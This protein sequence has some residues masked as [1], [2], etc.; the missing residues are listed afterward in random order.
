MC[1]CST[2]DVATTGQRVILFPLRCTWTQF[3]IFSLFRATVNCIWLPTAHLG[4]TSNLQ[5]RICV[6]VWTARGARYNK[7]CMSLRKAEETTKRKVQLMRQGQRVGEGPSWGEV[8]QW[9]P[10]HPRACQRT[11]CAVFTSL[12]QPIK[13]LLT[14]DP[15]RSAVLGLPPT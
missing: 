15:G 7:V 11:G 6:F 12:R 14:G 5:I 2:S 1:H 9:H 10:A 3:N 13:L 4:L 8:R